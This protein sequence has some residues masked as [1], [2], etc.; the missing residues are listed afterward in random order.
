MIRP[1]S[2]SVVDKIAGTSYAPTTYPYM[3]IGQDRIVAYPSNLWDEVDVPVAPANPIIDDL[4]FQRQKGKTLANGGK[5]QIFNT[6]NRR[7]GY[8]KLSTYFNVSEISIALIIDNS[9]PFALS[10]FDAFIAELQRGVLQFELEETP[11][12]E[13]LIWKHLVLASPINSNQQS[14]LSLPPAPLKF[15]L[16]LI[17]EAQYNVRLSFPNGLVIPHDLAEDITVA[18]LQVNLSGYSFAPLVSAMA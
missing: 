7:G 1:G 8:I 4:L 16:G 13:T 11:F 14:M 6:N 17:P 12:Y 15:D 2:P 10:G 3:L 5:V 18:K 9:T